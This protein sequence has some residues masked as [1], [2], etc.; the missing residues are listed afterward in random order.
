MTDHRH[1]QSTIARRPLAGLVVGND[2]DRAD[3]EPASATL[4]CGGDVLADGIDG[5]AK[6]VEEVDGQEDLAG[7]QGVLQ[8][9]T[10]S[11]NR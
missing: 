8:G 6:G 9:R 11:N 3:H 4:G 10:K 2:L 7:A 5:E 1:C